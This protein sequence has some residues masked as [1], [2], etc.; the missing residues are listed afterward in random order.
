MKRKDSRFCSNCGQHYHRRNLIEAWDI[1]N[2]GH[3]AG[4]H[5]TQLKICLTCQPRKVTD[6]IIDIAQIT[7]LPTKKRRIA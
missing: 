3:R 6:R 7:S 2:P 4:W 5:K 1:R